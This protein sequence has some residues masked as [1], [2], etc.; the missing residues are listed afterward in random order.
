MYIR[1]A[2]IGAIVTCLFPSALFAVS[3]TS[4]VTIEVA[5][6]NH[7]LLCDAEENY[8]ACPSDCDAPATTTPETVPEEEPQTSSGAR[9]SIISQI[10]DI[11]VPFAPPAPLQATFEETVQCDG[12]SCTSSVSRVL[13]R[14]ARSPRR[15]SSG[16]V[17]GEGGLRIAT[18]EDSD[19]VVFLWNRGQA[20]RILRSP[21]Q[22][23]QSPFEGGTLIFEGTTGF[24]E[25]SLN[26]IAENLYYALF[27]REDDGS[28][29][30]P[31]LVLVKNSLLASPAGVSKT[32]SSASAFGF[33]VLGT[34]ITILIVRV[35]WFL[36]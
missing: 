35:I 1:L 25:D 4:I 30:D 29:A 6:C 16:G 22:F 17:Y 24:F 23:P 21:E 18:Q 33:A 8:T 7:D 27:V 36:L 20:V 5:F 19:G 15:N 28:Y 14:F 34:L 31:Q 32:M 9:P 13:D 3:D 11:F 26:T 10:I 2:F 12:E